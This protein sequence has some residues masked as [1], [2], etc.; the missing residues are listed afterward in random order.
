VIA[1][2]VICVIVNYVKYVIANYVICVIAKIEVVAP[3]DLD[4]HFLFL[5]LDYILKYL[6]LCEEKEK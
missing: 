5:F 1:N 3:N 6:Y 2:Y 4:H